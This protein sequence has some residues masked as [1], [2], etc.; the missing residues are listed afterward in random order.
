MTIR[1][2]RFGDVLDITLKGRL[3]AMSSQLFEN[4]LQQSY[5]GLHELNID[6]RDLEYIS[7]AG[8]R[9]LLSARRTMNGQGRMTVS[10]ARH[11][12]ME[13][14]DTTGFSQFLF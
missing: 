10:G 1:K 7:S 11:Q 2:E 4:E 5:S 14:L 3:D 12:V 9:V 13:A 8:L 6:I